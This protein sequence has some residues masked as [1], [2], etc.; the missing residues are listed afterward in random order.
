LRQSLPTVIKSRQLEF[1]I[2][3]L[4]HACKVPFYQQLFETTNFNPD[5]LS[6]LSDLANLPLTNRQDIENYPE[7]FGMNILS[8]CSDICLT[9]GTTGDPVVVPYTDNDLSRLGFNEM[10]AFYSAGIREHDK[11]LL[12]VTLDRCFI[13][14]LAYYL[15]LVQLGATAVR[16]GPGQPERQLELI[17]Q[18]HPSAIVG[19]PSF[20]LQLAKCA[21]KEG[22]E[23]KNSSVNKLITI[24][25]PIRKPDNNLTLLGRELEDSWQAQIYSS[26]GATELETAFGECKLACGGH[27][28]P[29]L[30]IVEIIDDDGQLIRTGKAGEIVVTPLGVEGFPLVRFRTGD[31]ARLNTSPCDCGWNTPRLGPIEGRLA[32]RLKVKGTTLYPQAILQTLQLI[33]GIGEAY[34]EVRSTF[35]LSDEITVYVGYDDHQPDEQMIINKL[36][37]KLRIRPNIIIQPRE[38]ILSIITLGGG[39]KPKKFFDLR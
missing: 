29:E 33:P 1:L 21:T 14:G 27:V 26:Y 22:Y 34:V 24:G 31:I 37:A 19:V 30:M 38:E 11:V 8:S 6:Q 39:R 10:L 32:Q 3:H 20:L 18:L 23:L 2:K 36:Q 15:G 25:E 17:D 7:L 9:S 5:D 13:A 16:S 28:H 12:T 4:H 35:D